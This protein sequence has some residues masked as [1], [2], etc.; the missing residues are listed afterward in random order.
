MADIFKDRYEEN[1]ET[2]EANPCL[3]DCPEF[4]LDND[5]EEIKPI[6]SL[7]KDYVIDNDILNNELSN[8]LGN[9][10][11]LIADAILKAQKDWESKSFM[12]RMSEVIANFQYYADFSES[13]KDAGAFDTVDDVIHYIKTPNNFDKLYNFWLELGY[14]S[15]QDEMFLLFKERVLENKDLQ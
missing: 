7:F 13:L 3:S 9:H 10:L 6:S 15:Q 1:C 14:P 12:N 2:C 5:I 11:I 4:L 8:Q